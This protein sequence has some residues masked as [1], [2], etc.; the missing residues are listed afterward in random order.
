MVL[1]YLEEKY[2]VNK[3]GLIIDFHSSDF[4]PLR[5]FDLVILV[6]CDNEVLYKRLE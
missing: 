5:Y 4:F 6:R 3:G 2:D 1:D